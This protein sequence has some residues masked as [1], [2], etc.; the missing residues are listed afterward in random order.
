MVKNTPNFVIDR[1]A[2]YCFD[3]LVFS[4][5]D[6]TPAAKL[7]WFS[8]N[9]YDTIDDIVAYGVLKAIGR[10]TAAYSFGS[11]IAWKR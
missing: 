11:S 1:K 4:K 8:A 10:I 6:L 9:I 3:S 2:N 5:A 7:R